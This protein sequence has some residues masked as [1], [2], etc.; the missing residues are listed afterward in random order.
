MTSHFLRSWPSFPLISFR[1]RMSS[2]VF[3]EAPPDTCSPQSRLGRVLT[4]LFSETPLPSLFPVLPLFQHPPQCSHCCPCLLSLPKGVAFGVSQVSVQT[5]ALLLSS[6]VIV[7][8]LLNSLRLSLLI[9]N[10]KHCTSS[11]GCEDEI[12]LSLWSTA[13]GLAVSLVPPT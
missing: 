11:Q 10:Q 3:Q 7:G 13:Q 12:R 6:S 1:V 4:C 8:K 9:W 5:P 2:D